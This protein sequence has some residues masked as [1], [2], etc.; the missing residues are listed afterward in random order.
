MC[1]VDTSGERKCRDV[2]IPSF[3]LILNSRL[4]LEFW[5]KDALT[6]DDFLGSVQIH[7]KHLHAVAYAMQKPVFDLVFTI[8]NIEHSMKSTGSAK[9]THS[10]GYWA[11]PAV[12]TLTVSFEA[13]HPDRVQPPRLET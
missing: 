11:H 1:L 7:M 12:C 3:N 9:K 5:D 4:I 2:D 13:L 8:G 10:L 6:A